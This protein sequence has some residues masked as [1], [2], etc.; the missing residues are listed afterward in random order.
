MPDEFSVCENIYK[1]AK[2]IIKQFRGYIK[3][4]Y[5]SEVNKKV[6]NYTNKTVGR[7]KG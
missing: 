4:E 5:K 7:N 1:V 2:K 6:D 3:T